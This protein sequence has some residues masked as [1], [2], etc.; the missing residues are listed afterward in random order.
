M[1]RDTI[2]LSRLFAAREGQADY[3]PDA[4]FNGDGWVDGNDLAYLVSNLGR[5]WNGSNWSVSAGPTQ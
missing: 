2:W 5:C 1:P 4:D 3:Y